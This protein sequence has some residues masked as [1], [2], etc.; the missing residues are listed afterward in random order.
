[1]RPEGSHLAGLRSLVCPGRTRGRPKTL[2]SLALE[3]R[4]GPCVARVAGRTS[5][6]RRCSGVCPGVDQRALGAPC[7]AAMVAILGTDV[8]V[9]GSLGRRRGRWLDLLSPGEV[10]LSLRAGILGHRVIA[11]TLSSGD[12]SL[13]RSGLW[14]RGG[15]LGLPVT[16]LAGPARAG[17]ACW[18]PCVPGLSCV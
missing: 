12:L 2:P 13:E 16:R 10:Y 8:R 14:M 9:A 3:T 18:G 6:A 11:D 7:L 5:L 15:P 4:A 17:A 1:M